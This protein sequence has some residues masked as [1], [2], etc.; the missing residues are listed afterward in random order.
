MKNFS[1]THNNAKK[2]VPIFSALPFLYTICS[3]EQRSPDCLLTPYVTKTLFQRI[4]PLSHY[5]VGAA[6]W[7]RYGWHSANMELFRQTTAVAR[8][9]HGHTSAFVYLTA[10]TQLTAKTDA[11]A[12][13]QCKPQRLVA[14][15]FLKC[16]KG[17]DS[18]LPYLVGHA[19]AVITN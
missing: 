4:K 11:E 13:C 14:A 1:L 5:A 16:A 2:A 19:V 9:T 12:F 17:R 7:V 6:I 15:V 8:E 3:G 10:I 18:R